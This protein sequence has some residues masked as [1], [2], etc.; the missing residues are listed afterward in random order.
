[1]IVAASVKSATKTMRW[2][3][4]KLERLQAGTASGSLGR[5]LGD[6]FFFS[7]KQQQIQVRRAVVPLLTEATT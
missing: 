1:M 3:E 2:E 7:S 6:K 5:D 4:L